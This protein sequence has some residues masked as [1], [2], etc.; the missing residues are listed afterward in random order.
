M[1]ITR[2]TDY[3]LRI[4]RSLSGGG[5]FTVGVMAEREAL[6]HKFAYKILKKLERAKMVKMIR[7]VNGGCRLDCDLKEVTLYD[8][9]NAVGTCP[10]I[11]AC[12]T[13]NYVCEWCDLNGPCRI[14]TQLGKVQEVIDAELRTRSLHWIVFGDIAEEKTE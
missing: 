1:L 10:N 11:S 12:I 8:L 14:N 5:S 3:A 13:E 7:G 2:E 4:L 9:F 6:P